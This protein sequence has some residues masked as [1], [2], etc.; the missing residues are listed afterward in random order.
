MFSG[1]FSEILEFV[2]KF[3]SNLGNS[4]VVVPTFPQKTGVVV[5]LTVENTTQNWYVWR[6]DRQTKKMA[7]HIFGKADQQPGSKAVGGAQP[8]HPPQKVVW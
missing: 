3:R 7:E 8:G 2:T 6:P 4:L 1:R 5:T